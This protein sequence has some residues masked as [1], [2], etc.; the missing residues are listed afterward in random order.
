MG[1]GYLGIEAGKK[2]K[3][4]A[5]LRFVHSPE[6][7]LFLITNKSRKQKQKPKTN[8]H[9]HRQWPC[10]CIVRLHFFLRWV[11]WALLWS[12]GRPPLRGAGRHLMTCL[13]AI[14]APTPVS[15]L[16][17]IL[18]PFFYGDV[19]S[20]HCRSSH[21]PWQLDLCRLRTANAGSP[22]Y[23]LSSS[24]KYVLISQNF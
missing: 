3:K 24:F 16:S 13:L 5:H 20:P 9:L 14:W 10:W 21:V 15:C 1:G 17:P 12:H 19:F 22:D 7:V 2:K 6:C 18:C 4:A 11:K 8:V 23:G